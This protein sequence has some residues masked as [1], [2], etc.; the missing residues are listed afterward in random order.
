MNA[1]A[2]A[3]VQSLLIGDAMEGAPAAVF[4][5]DDRHQFLAVNRFACDLLGYTRDELLERT[6]DAVAPNADVEAGLAAL[7]RD[8]RREGTVELKHRD[9]TFVRV[10]YWA[11][12][13][14]VS[15]ISFWIAIAVPE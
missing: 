8:G 15:G 3:A 7:R 12:E 2:D 9:G 5:V 11:S 10:R 14:T 13:T 6:A 1:A 4:V